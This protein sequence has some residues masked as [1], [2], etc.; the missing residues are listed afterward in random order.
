MTTSGRSSHL[1]P[2]GH[3]GQ[4]VSAASAERCQ[5]ALSGDDM[6]GK[7][8]GASAASDLHVWVG[9]VL[10]QHTSRGG[11][12]GINCPKKGCP[13]VPGAQRNERSVMHCWSCMVAYQLF[14]CAIYTR[15][16]WRP[17]ES[18]ES[19][20]FGCSA[21]ASSMALVSPVLA[22]SPSRGASC[23]GRCEQID[24]LVRMAVNDNDYR[25]SKG[26]PRRCACRIATDPCID[27]LPT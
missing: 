23:G 9:P 13:S 14:V 26:Q 11:V 7:Q 15:W 16:V 27:V 3:H 22:R 17:Y 8:R 24:G 6:P 12:P 25:T 5:I 4:H 19:T 21:I 18:L 10:Q 1:S 2:S 20:S